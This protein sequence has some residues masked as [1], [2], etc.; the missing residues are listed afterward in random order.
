[1]QNHLFH[2]VL[3]NKN[4]VCLFTLPTCASVWL[5][6]FHKQKVKAVLIH[7]SEQ[8][9]IPVFRLEAMF[10]QHSKTKKMVSNS[11]L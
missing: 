10:Q 3:P 9:Q 5:L 1:M 7:F 11:T 2:I 8:K 6:V 4:L